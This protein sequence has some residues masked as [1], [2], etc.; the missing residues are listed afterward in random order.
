MKLVFTVCNDSETNKAIMMDSFVCSF[1][2]PFV[3]LLIRSFGR[4]HN[5]GSQQTRESLKR[6]RACISISSD[7]AKTIWYFFAFCVLNKLFVSLFTSIL[8]VIFIIFN[9][10]YFLLKITSSIFLQR[11]TVEKLSLVLTYFYFSIRVGL[12]SKIFSNT[13]YEENRK[14]QWFYI[15]IIFEAQLFL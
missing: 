3:C 4:C 8:S 10:K 9:G 5:P 12:R 1:V 6:M 13:F 15:K 11:N 14:R 7:N 2:C